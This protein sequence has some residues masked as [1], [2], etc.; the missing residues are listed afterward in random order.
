MSCGNFLQR[1]ETICGIKPGFGK[2][3]LIY[4]EAGVIP[5]AD[6]TATE[7]QAAIADGSIIG[8]IQGWNTVAGASVAE[9]NTEKLNG[10]MK[11]VKSE[12]LA[13]TLTFE[14]NITNNRVFEEL[15]KGGTYDC[16]LLDDMGYA[17]GEQSLE[18]ASIET[19]KMNFSGKTSNGLQSDQTN[20]QTVA[21]TV[22]YLVE[23]IGFL[24]AGVEVEDIVSKI[25]L[26]AKISSVTSQAADTIVFVLDLFDETNG[27]LLT[28]FT[29]TALDVNAVV[30]GNVVTAAGSFASNQLTL[31]LTKTV[32][33]FSTTT[34]KIKLDL[35]TESYYLTEIVF[36][37]ATFA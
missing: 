14:N 21:V 28:A 7:I 4:A 34:N 16:I 35:S 22:R 33:D 32:A 13:D 31:T 25:P 23:K 37:T 27:E 8:I 2:M 29:T 15:V 30:N 11:L 3:I 36:N 1:A 17:F 5:I 10:E 19:M 20:E 12:I 6:L 18:P 24:N 9:K 26:I